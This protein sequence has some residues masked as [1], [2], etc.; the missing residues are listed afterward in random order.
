VALSKKEKRARLRT[1]LIIVGVVLLFVGMQSKSLVQ[2][3]LAPTPPGYSK[4]PPPGKWQFLDW[5]TLQKTRWQYGIQPKLPEGL[6]EF[7]GQP[8]RVRGFMLPLHAAT[9]GSQWFVSARPRGCYF[10]DP[11]GVAEVIQ[12]NMPEGQDIEP[13]TWQV[14]VYGTFHIAPGQPSDSVLYWIDEAVVVIAF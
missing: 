4:T 2:A 9:K 3:I 7:E 10:C 14:D 13:S 8:V 6:A 11:P 1:I 5:D 12:V